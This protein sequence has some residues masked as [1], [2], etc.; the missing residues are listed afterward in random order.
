MNEH[1]RKLRDLLHAADLETAMQIGESY[2]AADESAKQRI[3]QRVLRDTDSPAEDTEQTAAVLVVKRTYWH[4]I[5]AAAAC[6]LLCGGMIGGAMQ[7]RQMKTIENTEPASEAT[8]EQKT[9]T[10]VAATK[11]AETVM[12]TTGGTSCSTHETILATSG[13]DLPAITESQ[14]LP[15][16]IPAQTVPEESTQPSVTVT[17]PTETAASTTEPTA[18]KQE[19]RFISLSEG[20]PILEGFTVTQ[21]ENEFGPKCRIGLDSAAMPKKSIDTLYEAIW[22]PEGWTANSENEEKLGYYKAQTEKGIRFYYYENRY[23]MK[24]HADGT[25]PLT[26]F[27]LIVAQRMQ[28][29][30]LLCKQE[31]VLGGNG[32]QAPSDPS[33][34]SYARVSVN[35]RPAFIYREDHPNINDTRSVWYTLYWEQD[36]YLFSIFAGE[37]PE[38]YLFELIRIAESVQPM[39]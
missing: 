10:A 32:M 4:S 2:P 28:E 8:S 18:S 16:E 1:E 13:L 33:L 17:V 38:S 27:Y 35:G 22:L 20:M 19:I 11:A 14:T 25:P 5:A 34:Y 21:V 30:E 29:P 36:G 23:E 3:M 12:Q 15:E 6:L 9:E 31:Y 7:H 37:I 39:G 24:Y 26:D